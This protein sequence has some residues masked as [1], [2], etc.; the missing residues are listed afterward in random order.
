MKIL[1][2]VDAGGTVGLGHFYRSVNL[3]QQLKQ[4]GHDVY[5]S[6]LNSSFWN[7]TTEK[8]FEF[9]CFTL[10]HQNSELQTLEIISQNN[11]E[12]YYVD[13]FIDF[14]KNFINQLKG[15]VKIIFYQN[16][17]ESRKYADI[18]ILPSIHQG[19]DFFQVFNSQTKV[20]SGLKYFIF[21]PVL[22]NMDHKKNIIPEVS[23]V[24]IA[25]GG[26]DPKNS[27]IILYD[28]IAQLDYKNIEFTFYYGQ[29]Y[30]YKQSIPKEHPNNIH[31]KLFDHS[32]II[33]NEI[34]I[35]AFG[36]S[37]YEFLY[38]GIPILSFG[39]QESNAFASTQLALKTNSLI[40]LG[41][42]SKLSKQKLDDALK[43]ILDYS[44]RK[45]ITKKAQQ[46][47]DLK[48]T[49][50]VIEIIEIEK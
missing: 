33:K 48:G 27:L 9:K 50:R 3:A 39:H 10:D 42:I 38:L 28:H 17:C 21:N 14:N 8:E 6:H 32:E 34:L 18:F 40:S 19:S 30:L 2:R 31:F 37:T 24:G 25:A 11:I 41:E 20:F 1:F 49:E 23:N 5:F 13:G 45:E 29:D 46:I 26:S 36:V 16:I 35:T 44:V 22:Y 43:T 47:L 12:I 4:R 15:K 7:E